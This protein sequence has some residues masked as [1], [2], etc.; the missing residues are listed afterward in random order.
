M[1]LLL[2]PENSKR[3][4][5]I[6]IGMYDDATNGLIQMINQ[7]YNTLSNRDDRSKQTIFLT[8]KIN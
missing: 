7:I 8:C 6:A 3:R 1:L 5:T 4:A 2:N